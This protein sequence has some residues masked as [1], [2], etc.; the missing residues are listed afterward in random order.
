VPVASADEF[1]DKVAGTLTEVAQRP[2]TPLR[3]SAI[4]GITKRLISQG[5]VKI[6]LRDVLLREAGLLK[7]RID[8]IPA[9]SPDEY[10]QRLADIQ[11]AGQPL[12]AA[13]AAGCFYAPQERRL[14]TDVFRLIAAQPQPMTGYAWQQGQALRRLPAAMALYAGVLGAWAAGDAALIKDLLRQPLRHSYIDAAGELRQLPSCPA[15]VAL[16]PPEVI[17]ID[18]LGLGP[19]AYHASNKI[20][21]AIMPVL[22]DEFPVGPD[23]AAAFEEAEYLMAL[24]QH[25]W[26]E[27][28]GQP[29]H[30]RWARATFHS[31]LIGIPGAVVGPQPEPVASRFES[32]PGGLDIHSFAGM[33]GGDEES[34]S[35]S[36][37]AIV[38][39]LKDST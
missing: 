32:H 26:H 22:K 6:E 21:E 15:F 17:D 36:I 1:F 25:N 38:E 23:F 19:G 7:D 18:A 5:R 35:N 34:E 30:Q 3:T 37:A 33:F 12:A 8:R 14:W 20:V 4:V 2:S 27:A 9:F 16:A 28:T 24:L 10:K 13:L 11:Q 31:G 39:Y 29:G